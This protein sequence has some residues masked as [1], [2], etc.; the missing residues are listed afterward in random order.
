MDLNILNNMKIGTKGNDFIFSFID[1]LTQAINNRKEKENNMNL[2]NN[3]DLSTKSRDEFVIKRN[4][5][6]TEYAN[7]TS[8]KG[9]MYY[10]YD[11]NS[12]NENIF[13]ATICENG[14]SHEIVE[15][16]KNQLPN[17]VEIGS[18]LR[19][20]NNNY[21][22]DEQATV[23]IKNRLDNI[24]NNLIKKQNLELENNRIEGHIYEVSEVGSDRVYLFDISIDDSNGVDEIEE[25][26][27]SEEL[28]SALNEG[29]TLIYENGEYRLN[30]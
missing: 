8:N 28:L 20:N 9:I 10:I 5:I 12:N 11:K 30:S 16:D 1:E 3:E 17:E 13:N 6:L 4:E 25:R 21:Y 14:K 22:I 26:N 15:L 2:Q 24:K 18:V 19:N 29:D 7:E 27:I 23:K